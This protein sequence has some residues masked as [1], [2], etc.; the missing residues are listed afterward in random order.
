MTVLDVVTLGDITVD[1][2]ARVP[3]YPS[4]GGDSLAERVDIRAGGSAANTAIV[5][6][7][8][9]PS[10]GIIAR[11]GEDILADR[12]L[13]DLREAGVGLSC[14][15]RD[16]QAMTGLVFAAV[17]P[18]GERTFFSCRGANASTEPGLVDQGIIRQA[19]L[20]HVSGYALVESPQRETA[21]QAIQVAHQVG[22]PVTL[23]LGVEVTTTAREEILAMLSMASM[24]Y[25]NRAVAEWLTGMRSADEM[26]QALLAYGPATV[27]LK[28]GDQGCMIGSAAG[29]FHVP[30]FTVDAVDDTG[31]GDSFNAG[32][33]LGR[34]SGLSLRESGLLAN[35]LGALA[36]TVTGAGISLPGRE[37]A[38]SFLE[39]QRSEFAWQDWSDEL[40]RL[41]EFSEKVSGQ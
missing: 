16:A 12:A 17:T 37:A 21:R 38:L 15:Q 24:V 9:G 39:K 3:Y 23:D 30:A 28:L 27:G 18:D 14:V 29:L 11:V 1:I 2:V 7:K 13:A 34:L 36:T 41:C 6:S 31:A 4:L 32:L 8:F 19:R 5:L 35:A 25:P 20:L 33:I 10:V 40:G 22:V 26:A